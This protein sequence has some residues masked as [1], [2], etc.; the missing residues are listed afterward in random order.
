M[1]VYNLAGE[2]NTNFEDFCMKQYCEW[3]ATLHLADKS[4]TT[5]FSQNIFNRQGHGTTKQQNS[6]SK[7]KHTFSTYLNKTLRAYCN[8]LSTIYVRIC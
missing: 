5:S 3:I 1:D 4:I 2:E 6:E 7:R 8:M